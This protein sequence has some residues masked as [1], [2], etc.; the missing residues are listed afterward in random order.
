RTVAREGERTAIQ[1]NR[2]YEGFPTMV[3]F[4]RVTAFA[5]ER[6]HFG[7]IGR[8]RT[9]AS[10]GSRPTSW[11]PG[12]ARTKT[13]RTLVMNGYQWGQGQQAWAAVWIQEN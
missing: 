8:R 13:E 3:R 12:P 9:Q 7:Y 4:A 1:I 2:K 6:Q 10:A 5:G 11:S